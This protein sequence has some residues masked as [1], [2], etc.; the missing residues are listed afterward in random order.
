MGCTLYDRVACSFAHERAHALD[1]RSCRAQANIQVSSTG[2]SVCT[3]IRVFHCGRTPV[4]ASEVASALPYTRV[5]LLSYFSLINKMRKTSFCSNSH[6]CKFVLCHFVSFDV[7]FE[8]FS[9]KV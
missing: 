2:D 8:M 5:L 3:Y 1:R 7:S 6:V 9:P 4:Q